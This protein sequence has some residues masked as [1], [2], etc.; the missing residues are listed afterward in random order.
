MWSGAL[1]MFLFFCEIEANAAKSQNDADNGQ[2][3]VHFSILQVMTTATVIAISPA[4]SELN[5]FSKIARPKPTTA[6]LER[7]PAMSVAT[8]FFW[9][10]ILS[11]QQR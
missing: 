3:H 1:L 10:D 2:G 11:P 8:A 4:I 7:V 6:K 5:L 9:F